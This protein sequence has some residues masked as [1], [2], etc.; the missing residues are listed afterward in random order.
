MNIEA[1]FTIGILKGLKCQIQDNDVKLAL[2][3]SIDVFSKI[4]DG[5]IL[6]KPEEENNQEEV[7]EINPEEAGGEE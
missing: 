1:I 3:K 6:Q 2:E 7:E 4:S 5:Y